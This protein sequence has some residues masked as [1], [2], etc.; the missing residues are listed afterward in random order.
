MQMWMSSNQAVKEQYKY[1]PLIHDP[2]DKLQNMRPK[3]SLG[4]RL[5]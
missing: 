4:F 2:C 1:Y 5:D 3:Q